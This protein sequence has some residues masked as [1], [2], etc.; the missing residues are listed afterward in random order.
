MGPN[1]VYISDTGNHRIRFVSSGGMIS[2]F[3]G[4]GE[5]DFFGDNEPAELAALDLPTAVA[6]SSAN[7]LFIADNG[8]RRIRKV[9]SKGI[10]S[11]VASTGQDGFSPDDIPLNKRHS[12]RSDRSLSTM[13]I[14]ST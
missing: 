10:I 8:N 6:L 3:A 14:T 5:S 11:T 4:N 2:T 1:G 9:D 13:P 7:E 12:A